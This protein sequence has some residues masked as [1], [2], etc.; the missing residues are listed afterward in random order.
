MAARSTDAVLREQ[1]NDIVDLIFFFQRR[2]GITDS[3]FSE[4]NTR[5]QI[6]RK[7]I[8]TIEAP[9]YLETNFDGIGLKP[10]SVGGNM[11]AGLLTWGKLKPEGN[12][13]RLQAAFAV[14]TALVKDGSNIFNGAQGIPM[15]EIVKQGADNM[16]EALADNEVQRA[17]DAIDNIRFTT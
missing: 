14:A 12:Q 16:S 17:L 9:Q 6:T 5:V 2:L 3:G 10:K 11:I 7:G 1:L 15:D 13:T 8:A 4:V